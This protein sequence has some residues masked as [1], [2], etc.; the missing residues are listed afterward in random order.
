M[1][2]TSAESRKQRSG[3]GD[4]TQELLERIEALEAELMQRPPAPDVRRHEDRTLPAVWRYAFQ[5]GF[6]I[7]PRRVDRKF[8]IR[9]NEC[10]EHNYPNLRRSALRDLIEGRLTDGFAPFEILN[11]DHAHVQLVLDLADI[12]ETLRYRHGEGATST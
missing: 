12:G 1:A 9:V 11:G 2:K 6:G 5:W 8:E 10:L 7:N 3:N 4:E